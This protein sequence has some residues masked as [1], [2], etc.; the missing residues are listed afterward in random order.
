MSA[1]GHSLDTIFC[2]VEKMTPEIFF[3]NNSDI[4]LLRKIGDI[5][6]PERRV[7]RAERGR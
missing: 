5:F 4:S 6:A 7:Y 2:K 1:G 3:L